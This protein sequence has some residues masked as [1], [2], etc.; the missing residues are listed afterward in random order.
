L[1]LAAKRDRHVRF[2]ERSHSG[3]AVYS[4]GYRGFKSLSLRQ[5]FY[6]TTAKTSYTDGM[7]ITKLEHACL[8]ITEGDSR[9]I[10]DP[11]VYST[12]LTSL[13]GITAVVITH[14]HQDHLD[15]QKVA[16]IIAQNPDVHIFTTE[17]TAQKLPNGATTVPAIGQEYSIGNFKLEFFGG[18]HAIIMDNFPQDQ[19]YGVLVNDTFYYP[20]DSLVA[21]PKPHTV[22]AVPSMAPWLKL[23]EAAQFLKN[24]PAKQVFPTHNGFVNEAGNDLINRLLSGVAEQTGKT[25]QALKPGDSVEA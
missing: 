8:D 14:V 3:K 7:K 10:V 22:T 20:G 11:G 9:L 13:Q 17:Q 25:Y 2:E 15:E 23:N 4:Q 19:N 16:Q 18:M 5:I 24:D 1:P 21:C 12:S 6:I